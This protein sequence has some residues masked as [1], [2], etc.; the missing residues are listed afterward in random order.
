MGYVKFATKADQKQAAERGSWYDR[1]LLKGVTSRSARKAFRLNQQLTQLVK[2]VEK[3]TKNRNEK[4]KPRP[5][6]TNSSR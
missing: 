5:R 6:S 3:Q 2:F 4:T 1:Y